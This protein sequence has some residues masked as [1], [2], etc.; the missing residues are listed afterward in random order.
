LFF[1]ILTT[2]AVVL[3]VFVLCKALCALWEMEAKGKEAPHVLQ[4]T[5]SYVKH[6]RGA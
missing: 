1:F 5:M 2:C 4:L 3:I 6:V